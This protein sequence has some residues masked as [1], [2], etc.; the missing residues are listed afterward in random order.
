[1]KIIKELPPQLPDNTYIS[2]DTEWHGINQATMHRPTTG[3][4]A[5][6]TLCYQPDEVYFIDD[7]KKVQ[8]ARSAKTIHFFLCKRAI[9]N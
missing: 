9:L 2:L 5:C 8:E 4:F 7:E 6:L 1:M 3:K